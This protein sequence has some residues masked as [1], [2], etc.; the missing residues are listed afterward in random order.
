VFPIQSAKNC[1]KRT[2]DRFHR[3]KS[4]IDADIDRVR[5]KGDTDTDKSDTGRQLK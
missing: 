2:T 5:K 1:L 3:R 4:K